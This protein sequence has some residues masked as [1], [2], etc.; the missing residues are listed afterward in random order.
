[1]GGIEKDKAKLAEV[2]KV[3]TELMDQIVT[4]G[5]SQ[6]HLDNVLRQQMANVT[7]NDS[8][9]AQEKA[10]EQEKKKMLI[11]MQQKHIATL[12]AEVAIFMQKGGHVYTTV[13]QNR[14]DNY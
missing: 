6:L 14:Q 3:N 5:W 11:G 9:L 12:K 2:T 8:E 10:S 4:M 7:V 13:T 1:M